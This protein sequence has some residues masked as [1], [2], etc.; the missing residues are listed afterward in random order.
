VFF[1]RFR[2]CFAFFDTINPLLKTGAIEDGGIIVNVCYEVGSESGRKSSATRVWTTTVL[3]SA[4]IRKKT[5]A[6]T[7]SQPKEQVRVFAA[8]EAE[9]KT[10]SHSCSSASP[11]ECMYN[12]YNASSGSSA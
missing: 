2:F 3:K 12:L 9:D 10:L 7:K 5:H 8:M 4:K 11:K 1:F 6:T